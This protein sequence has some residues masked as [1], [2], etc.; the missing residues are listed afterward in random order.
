MMFRKSTFFYHVYLL[1]KWEEIQLKINENKM[2][3]WRKEC[4]RNQPDI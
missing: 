1:R 3:K 4:D 2:K